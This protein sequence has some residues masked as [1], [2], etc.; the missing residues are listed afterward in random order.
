MVIDF[1]VGIGH[2]PFRELEFGAVTALVEHLNAEGIEK[3]V[4]YPIA[5][6]LAKDCMWGNREVAGAA[7]SHPGQLIPF[8]CINPA[9]PGW[10]RDFAEC[11]GELGFR[12]LR[13]YPTY[14]GYTLDDGCAREILAAAQ[15]IGVPAALAVR[16]EDERQHHWLVKVPPLDLGAAAGAIARFQKTRFILSAATYP[17]M[18]AVAPLLAGRDN[19]SVDIARMQGRHARPGPVEVMV[20]AVEEFGAERILFGSNLPFQYLQASL[21]KVRKA[22]ID[23]GFKEMILSRNAFR[24]L[25][26]AGRGRS[27]GGK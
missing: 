24:L 16:V 26:T 21:L 1:L 12:G 27:P 14:H 11:F 5:A 20:R 9:F 4:V 22:A 8:A 13:L 10:E 7:A 23:P 17:E 25:E 2:W 18:C 19:W 15:E 3:A 6:I